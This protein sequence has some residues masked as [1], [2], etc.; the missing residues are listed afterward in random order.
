MIQ[1][2]TYIGEVNASQVENLG[3]DATVTF[4]EP[5][6]KEPQLQVIVVLMGAADGLQEG[7]VVKTVSTVKQSGNKWT[8]F[9]IGVSKLSGGSLSDATKVH[10]TWLALSD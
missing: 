3:G 4:P 10:V 5:F 1:S 9:G 2:G 7:A 6:R 8:G